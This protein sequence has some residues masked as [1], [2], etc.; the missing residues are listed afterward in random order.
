MD[1][2]YK[3]YHDLKVAELE[4]DIDAHVQYYDDAVTKDACFEMLEEL[5]RYLTHRYPRIFYLADGVLHN[6]VTGEKLRYPAGWS[7]SLSRACQHWVVLTANQTTRK[8][9]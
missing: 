3:R 2:N 1:S 5:T 9:H 4:K 7:L 8:K 6:T